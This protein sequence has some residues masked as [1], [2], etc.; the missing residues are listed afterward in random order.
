[1]STDA[2]DWRFGTDGYDYFKG[3]KKSADIEGR[4]PSIRQASDLVGPGIGAAATRI[5]DFNN[6]LATFNGYYS[7]LPGAIAAPNAT[8]AFVGYVV[9]DAELGGFQVFTGLVSGNQYTRTFQRSPTDPETIGWGT[10]TGNRVPPTV[11]ARGRVETYCQPGVPTILLPP[12]FP[13]VTGEAGVYEFSSAGIRIRK[14]GVYTGVIQVG[15]YTGTA[16]A[17]IYPNLPLG[18]F[19]EQMGQLSVPLAPTVHIPFTTFVSD[20]EQG[21]SVTAVLALST[22]ASL[23]LWWRFSCT[24]VGDAS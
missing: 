8:E 15:D 16:V 14:P 19:T 18:T 1:M 4:R 12:E 20:A 3:Q 9:S 2:K 23:N 24:R 13:Q 21:I 17:D 11:V 6:L 7:A 5:T 22:P 10:W